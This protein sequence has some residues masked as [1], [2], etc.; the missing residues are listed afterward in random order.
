MSLQGLAALAPFIAYLRPSVSFI[1]ADFPERRRRG[2]V[3]L[4]TERRRM[5]DR[6]PCWQFF[7]RGWWIRVAIRGVPRATG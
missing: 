2:C 4:V 7:V 1:A 3:L 6:H 5:G